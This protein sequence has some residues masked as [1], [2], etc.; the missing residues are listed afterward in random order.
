MSYEFDEAKRQAYLDKHGCNIIKSAGK[1]VSS[2]RYFHVE[3]KGKPAILME[4]IPDAIGD[5]WPG[6]KMCDYVKLGN[7]LREHGLRTPEIY[8]VD[9]EG[10]YMLLEDFGEMFFAKAAEQGAVSREELYALAVDVLKK[11]QALTD[12][13][14]L[15]AYYEGRIHASHKH[16]I[17]QAL[18]FL[19]GE[20]NPEG[21][22][23]Q[24]ED[25]WRGIES[26]YP[27]CPQSFMHID[28]HA[29]NLMWLPDAQG[30]D[31]CGILDYQEAMIGP[32]AYDLANLLEDA[33]IDVPQDI[34]DAMMDRY[35]EGMSAGEREVFEAWF[36]ILATQFHCRVLGLFI[37]LVHQEGVEKYRPFIPVLRAHLRRGLQNPVLQPLKAFFDDLAVDF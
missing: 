25:I 7:Y 12:Y 24:Y 4:A 33:R 3:C 20:D 8:D 36:R 2:R 28:F 18:P 15:P 35:C 29:E 22:V 37:R 19:R 30:T 11:M 1:D 14:E 31:R 21:L 32:C 13:P 16:I 9:F 23:E 10:G 6:H 26:R 34:R 27:P 17:T 5:S